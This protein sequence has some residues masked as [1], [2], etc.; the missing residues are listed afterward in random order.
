MKIHSLV[1]E[2]KSRKTHRYRYRDRYIWSDS[3]SEIER[4][5]KYQNNCAK[6]YQYQYH[7]S[8]RL[9]HRNFESLK[10]QKERVDIKVKSGAQ[11]E[12]EIETETENK[13]ESEA[14]NQASDSNRNQGGNHGEG[15]K[16][17]LDSNSLDLYYRLRD[18]SSEQILPIG[19]FSK[20]QY[21]LD[22]IEQGIR[23]YGP[24]HILASYNGGKDAVVIMHLFRAAL[25]YYKDGKEKRERA[26]RP[27]DGSQVRSEKEE[28]KESGHERKEKEE[29]EGEEKEISQSMNLESKRREGE[30]DKEAFRPRLIYFYQDNEFPEVEELVYTTTNLYNLDLK[31]YKNQ[32]FVEGLSSIIE[33][34]KGA[35]LAFILGTRY[36][37][38]NSKGQEAF[39]PS[40]TWMPPFM[41][42]N[43][44]LQWSY[45]DVW[46][47]LKEYNL[48]YCSLYDEGYTSLGN[49]VDTRPNPALLIETF[50]EYPNTTIFSNNDIEEETKGKSEEEAKENK[51]IEENSDIASSSS[52]S[53]SSSS[54]SIKE[55][56]LIRPSINKDG[57]KKEYYP[58]YM[59]KDWSLERANRINKKPNQK[60][61][62]DIK[63]NDQGKEDINNNNEGTTD[64]KKGKS[65]NHPRYKNVGLIMI[66]DEILKGKTPD[67][68]SHYA[69][70]K[71]R[72]KGLEVKRVSIVG[73]NHDEIKRE[74]QLQKN[75]VD[76]IITSGGVGPTHD[77][78][79]IKAVASSLHQK[80]VVNEDMASMLRQVYDI[81]EDE[82]LSDSLIKMASLPEHSIL[83]IPPPPVESENENEKPTS[84]SSGIQWPI[85]QCDKV[86][87]LPGVPKFFMQKIDTIVDHFLGDYGKTVHR[88]KLVL[89]ADEHAIVEILNDAVSKFTKSSLDTSSSST[90]SSSSSNSLPSSSSSSSISSNVIF[91][92]YPILNDENRTIITLEG[93]NQEDVKIAKAYLLELL[94]K[95]IEIIKVEND[96]RFSGETEL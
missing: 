81:P 73:D 79:T 63:K 6:S 61:K 64:K 3:G 72:E 25:A 24:R 16:Q 70:K 36:A 90:P 74:I 50:H 56:A 55:E 31:V 75:L 52:S 87:I 51:E 17:E 28:N 45:G 78:I 9:S 13:A 53:S 10:S 5:S 19:L 85:L 43:P 8:R 57:Q 65:K 18:E 29:G 77:D 96:D 59:L 82:N 32:S 76:V 84:P 26:D 12:I 49:T 46:S 21:S 80:I 44:I 15:Q 95:E 83:R 68:N 67:T 62:S 30:N 39:S 4:H 27:A 47:F 69:I 14:M 60:V 22:I 2:Y 58:A 94:P 11:T 40:S 88:C 42:V 33:E 66:G 20:V 91:G 7:I 93:E 89:D 38:P 54:T 92:S 86:F 34:E 71:L 41:R 35:P 48:R 23:L 37:D 1:K